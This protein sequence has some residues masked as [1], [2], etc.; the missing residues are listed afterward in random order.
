MWLKKIFYIQGFHGY[1]AAA[2]DASTT[3]EWVR[4]HTHM[5]RFFQQKF[6]SLQSFY[7]LH[8]N[9][10]KNT[11]IQKQKTKQ[12]KQSGEEVTTRCFWDTKN[13]WEREGGGVLGGEEGTGSPLLTPATRACV[14]RQP[15]AEKWTDTQTQVKIIPPPRWYWGLLVTFRHKP[16]GGVTN[17]FKSRSGKNNWLLS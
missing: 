12:N 2:A 15:A 5:H 9:K 6:N 1:A 14:R 16:I 13:R 11:L 4:K 17:M 7:F 8:W 3:T 10:I